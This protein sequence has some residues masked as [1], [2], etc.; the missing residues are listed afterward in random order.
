M[1][2]GVMEGLSELRFVF[3]DCEHVIEDVSERSIPII[4]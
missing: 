1:L 3:E 4:G 2:V